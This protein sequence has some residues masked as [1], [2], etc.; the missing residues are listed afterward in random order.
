MW[1]REGVSSLDAFIQ[2]IERS[3]GQQNE[4]R[5]IDALIDREESW[6]QLEGDEEAGRSDGDRNGL[7]YAT[8]SPST[9]FISQTFVSF[10]PIMRSLSQ[11]QPASGATVEGPSTKRFLGLD[12]LREPYIQTDF[13]ILLRKNVLDVVLIWIQKSHSSTANDAYESSFSTF[14]RRYSLLPY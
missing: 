1:D 3:L 7:V 5:T 9:S 13:G 12:F 2:G 11:L 8:A 14:F 4:N 10:F 6:S